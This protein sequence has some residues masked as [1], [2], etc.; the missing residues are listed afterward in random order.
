[1]STIIVGAKWCQHSKNQFDAFKCEDTDGS[2]ACTIEEKEKKDSA[3]TKKI[4]FVWCED[5]NREKIFD[6]DGNPIHEVCDP[7]NFEDKSLM[8]GYPAWI[9]QENEKLSVMQTG[10]VNPCDDNVKQFFSGCD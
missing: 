7:N 9:H 4:D 10:M 3:A 8:T 6:V 2:I 5:E 1:M